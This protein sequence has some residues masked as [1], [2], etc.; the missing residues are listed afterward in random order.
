MSVE[1]KR[2]WV[3]VVFAIVALLLAITGGVELSKDF[4]SIL[5]YAMLGVGLGGLIAAFGEIVSDYFPDKVKDKDK[6]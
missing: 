6:K 4:S 1:K 3:I 2:S 5:G